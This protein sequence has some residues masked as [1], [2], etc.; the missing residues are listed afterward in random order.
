MKKL[1]MLIFGLLISSVAFSQESEDKEKEVSQ[2]TVSTSQ[3]QN[4]FSKE[5]IIVTPD[6]HLI[7]DEKMNSTIAVTNNRNLKILYVASTLFFT[8]NSAL[9]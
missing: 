3:Q 1:S 9:T 4:N 8:E 7:T 5:N 6:G 2:E